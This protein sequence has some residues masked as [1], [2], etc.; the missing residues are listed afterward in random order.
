MAEGGALEQVAE[1]AE[2]LVFEDEGGEGVEEDAAGGP[3][4]L[5]AKPEV[6]ADG[7]PL[8]VAVCA[9]CVENED[10]P[11]FVWTLSKSF[12][13]P[14]PTAETRVAYRQQALEM[15]ESKPLKFCSKLTCMMSK[16][17]KQS[18]CAAHRK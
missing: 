17:G 12:I 11:I 7:S 14:S 8:A 3:P 18:W 15:L 1:V 2:E 10:T 13:M 4:T 5:E 16:L 9:D 6:G